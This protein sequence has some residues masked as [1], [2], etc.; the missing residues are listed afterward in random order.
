MSQHLKHVISNGN[1][2]TQYSQY[3]SIAEMTRKSKYMAALPPL[4]VHCPALDGD[5]NSLPLIFEDLYQERSGMLNGG[6]YNEGEEI[7]IV[8]RRE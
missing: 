1:N 4:P 3:G 8:C 2:D 6:D 7:I 5:F